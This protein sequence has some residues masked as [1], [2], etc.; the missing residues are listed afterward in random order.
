MIRLVRFLISVAIAI[1]A[2]LNLWHL[3]QTLRGVKPREADVAVISEDQLRFVRDALMKAGYWRGD[4][5]YMPAGVL[6]GHQPTLLDDQQWILTRYGMLRW[7]IRA[8]T[9]AAPY[10]FGDGT[11]TSAAVE[12]PAGFARIYDSA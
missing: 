8:N 12:T 11:R 10:V 7:D 6:Q 4:V 2:F 5:G 3:D 1:V 9:L